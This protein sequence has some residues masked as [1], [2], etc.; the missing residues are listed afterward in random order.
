[1]KSSAQVL[2]IQAAMLPMLNKFWKIKKDVEFGAPKEPGLLEGLQSNSM[3]ILGSVPSSWKAVT[4]VAS[5]WF[6][7]TLKKQF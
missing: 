1:M 3:N 2:P 4:F 6:R 5:P 7:S